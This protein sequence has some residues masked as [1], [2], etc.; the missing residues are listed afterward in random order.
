M[1]ISSNTQKTTLTSQ[2]VEKIFRS[3]IK[4]YNTRISS[5]EKNQKALLDQLGTAT[6]LLKDHVLASEAVI[7]LYRQSL[8]TNKKVAFDIIVQNNPNLTPAQQKIVRQLLK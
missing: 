1:G 4:D 7:K 3:K 5:L 8:V 6:K 2:D